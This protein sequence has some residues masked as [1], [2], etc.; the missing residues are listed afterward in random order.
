MQQATIIFGRLSEVEKMQ[1]RRASPGTV[2]HMA[3]TVYRVDMPALPFEERVA[4]LTEVQ[5]IAKLA[6]AANS[7][8]EDFSKTWAF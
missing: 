2:E 6:F 7:A 8:R 4:I 3:D 1:L 5:A